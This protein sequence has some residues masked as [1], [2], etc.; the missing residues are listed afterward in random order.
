MGIL[1]FYPWLRMTAFTSPIEFRAFR[2]QRLPCRLPETQGR[3]RLSWLVPDPAYWHS[4]G[5]KLKYQ[6]SALL[7]L[8]LSRKQV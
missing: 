5:I 1:I 2:G 4:F 6:E 3:L 7:W 8:Q